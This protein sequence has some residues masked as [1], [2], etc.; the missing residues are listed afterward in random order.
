MFRIV[1][2]RFLIILFLILIIILGKFFPSEQESFKL[3]FKKLPISFSGLIF[4]FLYVL[5]NFFIFLDLKDILKIVGAV[6]YGAY[7]S[8]LFIYIAELINAYLF[9]NLSNILGKDFLEKVLKGKFKKLYE[10]IG[11]LS[12]TWIFLL[13]IVPLVPYRALDISFG[14]S[15]V[16]F[17]KYFLAVIL[18]SLPRIFFIQFPLAAVKEFSI[19]K[20]TV[21]FENHPIILLIFFIYCVFSFIIAF[22]LR[23]KFK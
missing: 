18:G 17:K 19:K 13:R 8:T 11:N 6:I 14:L 2:K 16:P 22:V 23:K 9:F 5:T 7:L 1:K 10:K 12:F 3:F 20:M 15:R 4:I 21:Y